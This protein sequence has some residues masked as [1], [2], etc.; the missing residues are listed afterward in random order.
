MLKLL[1]HIIDL[2]RMSKPVLRMY[3][4]YVET[5]R[6]VD[7]LYNVHASLHYTTVEKIGYPGKWK[8]TFFIDNP[9]PIQE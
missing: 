8:R 6:Y 3:F 1:L 5:V 4:T 2:G 7:N 9:L